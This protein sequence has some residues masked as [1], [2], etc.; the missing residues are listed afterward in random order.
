MFTTTNIL[1]LLKS[2]LKYIGLLLISILCIFLFLLSLRANV[3]QNIFD[4]KYLE[5]KNIL[6]TVVYIIQTTNTDEQLITHKLSLGISTLDKKPHVV[7]L[8][9]DEHMNIITER[10]T[11]TP[12]SYENMFDPAKF[13]A[14]RQ[15]IATHPYGDFR[16]YFKTKTSDGE[17]KD[18]RWVYTYFRWLMFDGKRKY[19]ACLGITQDA[20]ESNVENLLIFVLAGIIIITVFLN[21]IWVLPFLNRHYNKEY[22]LNHAI[23][24]NKSE[25]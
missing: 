6:D 24:M 16:V 4:E 20:I 8:V 5:Q 22:D 1:Y 15:L 21:V 19:L 7:G 25:S 13:P 11:S 9:F 3:R 10:H 14:F 23:N 12:T 17:I 2:N 18:G